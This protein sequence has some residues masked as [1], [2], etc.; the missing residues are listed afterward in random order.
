VGMEAMRS[1]ATEGQEMSL[2][3][4]WWRRCW[5]EGDRSVQQLVV[6]T[7]WRAPRQGSSSPLSK[8]MEAMG[9]WAMEGQQ[10][11]SLCQGWWRRWQGR[12]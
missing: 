8:S 2:C 4:G 6:F 1:W 9:S 7:E 3:R 10:R 12:L 11:M 5:E